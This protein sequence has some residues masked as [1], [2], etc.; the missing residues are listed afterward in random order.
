MLKHHKTFAAAATLLRS[1]CCGLA[2]PPKMMST[3]SRSAVALPPS[4]EPFRANIEVALKPAV[5]LSPCDDAAQPW[6]TKL[7]GVPYRELNQPWPTRLGGEKDNLAFLAQVNFGSLP[8]L[9]DFPSTGILQF[10]IDGGGDRYGAYD[11]F[12]G[13]PDD[14]PPQVR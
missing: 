14:P 2:V 10:F 6:S 7:G 12:G 13:V 8:P 1:S 4:L 11:G 5:V 3:S 9:P